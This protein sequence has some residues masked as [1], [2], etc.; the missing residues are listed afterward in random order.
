MSGS[1]VSV[2]GQGN[3]T[4]RC[5]VVG[6]HY[7]KFKQLP[8]ACKATTET[9]HSR[10]GKWQQNTISRFHQIETKDGNIVWAGGLSAAY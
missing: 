8:T 1:P 7:G 2:R 4:G 5:F 9:F 3:Q 10:V 6:I